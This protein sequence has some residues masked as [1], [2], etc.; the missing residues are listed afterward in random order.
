MW[1]AR[2]REV[3]RQRRG[4]R[5]R[6]SASSQ[7]KARR[8]ANSTAAAVM[9]AVSPISVRK[10]AFP[11]ILTAFAF[12]SPFSLRAT[13]SMRNRERATKPQNFVV[14]CAHLMV[15]YR[16]NR[17]ACR[18]FM[19]RPKKAAGASRH[20]KHADDVFR[21]SLYISAEEKAIA[22]YTAELQGRTLSDVLRNGI[23]SEATRSGIWKNGNLVE[24]YRQRVTA[25]KE[26]LEAEAQLKR[27][28]REHG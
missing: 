1:P 6:S 15:Q 17:K 5:A 13:G 7:R 21:V 22:I 12:P 9:A 27:K 28:G 10:P 23:F 3:C 16:S 4:S 20:G 26:I 19:A 18:N 11:D 2:I 24:K 25:Y 14:V 8:A